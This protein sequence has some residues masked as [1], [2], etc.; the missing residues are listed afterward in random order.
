V[1][2]GAIGASRTIQ[3]EDSGE[4]SIEIVTGSLKVTVLSAAGESLEGAAANL[5]F[6]EPK[7]P[8]LVGTRRTGRRPRIPAPGTRHLHDRGPE[9]GFQRRQETVEIRP[10]GET[11]L[12]VRLSSPD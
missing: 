10:G 12:L 7:L 5:E 4:I 3:L 1:G 11:V 6:L 2:A 8:I 9:E